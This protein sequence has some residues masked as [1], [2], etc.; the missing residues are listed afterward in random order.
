MPPGS[1]SLLVEPVV[2]EEG[3]VSLAC[4][5][6]RGRRRAVRVQPVTIH[7]KVGC[8]W[9]ASPRRSPS[10]G[11]AGPTTPLRF[12]PVDGDRLGLQ[13]GEP[14]V[15]HE[16]GN[17]TDPSSTFSQRG[18]FLDH[19][20]TLLAC[21]SARGR[22]RAV[23]VQ[24]VTIHH[25]V[26]CSWSARAGGTRP[27]SSAGPTTPLQFELEGLV[28]PARQTGEPTVSHEGGNNVAECSAFLVVTHD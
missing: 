13:T 25:K 26:G 12:E 20:A 15:S 8:S 10:T 5:S 22:R 9:S 21:A 7:H 11:S 14:T 19:S 24:P 2:S 28:P 27:S 17:E 3:L 6:A 4:A 18:T 1:K 16:G 23:R